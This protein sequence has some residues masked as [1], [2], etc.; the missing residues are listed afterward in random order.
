MLIKYNSRYITL[1]KVPNWLWALV[2]QV[3]EVRKEGRN[4][5]VDKSFFEVKDLSQF[6]FIFTRIKQGDV[7][8]L[9]QDA[10]ADSFD[11]VST[12]LPHTSSSSTQRIDVTALESKW[13]STSVVGK[14]SSPSIYFNVES[15]ASTDDVMETDVVTDQGE[16]LIKAL[17]GKNKLSNCAEKHLAFML[18][19]AAH[20]NIPAVILPSIFEESRIS[21]GR[22]LATHCLKASSNQ[23]QLWIRVPFTNNGLQTFQNLHKMIDGPANVG[24]MTCFDDTAI[25]AENIGKKLVLLHKFCGSNLRAVCFNTKAFLTNKKGYPTLSKAS[26]FLVIEVLKRLG[27]TIRVLVEGDL[28]H[29]AITN[30]PE[31][32]GQSGYLSYVQYLRHLRGKQDV[33]SVLDTEEGKMETDYLDHLQS[34][35]QPCF[36]NLEFSTYEVCKSFIM[37]A[38]CHSTN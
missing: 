25:T 1:W 21:Y 35:L 19:W 38:I 24:A 22:F 11:Y 28:L 27:R 34:P 20:M 29:H 10:R 7:N 37:I 15:Q 17:D 2:F 18:D 30:V 31:I 3:E 12:N 16:R 26:Q 23:V 13:W 4:M 9:L 33:T 8:E 32:I 5:I 14:V 36:D 6:L